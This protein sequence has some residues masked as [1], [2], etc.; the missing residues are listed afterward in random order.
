MNAKTPA[1]RDQTPYGRLTEAGLHG[2]LGYQLAQ[3]AITT[4]RVFSERV[5]QPSELRPVEFTILTLVHE[6]PGVSARQLA[7]AL[8]VTPPN[9]T[10]WIDKLERRGLIERERS[11]TDRRAQHIRTT[12]AGTTLARQSVEQVLEGEQTT[13]AALSPAE[14]AMLIE[15]LHK[16]ARCRRR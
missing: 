4:T 16:V 2:I 3:A 13:L 1:A 14:R 5:G 6:N 8:A 9:I 15:L 11:T 12:P 7:D 10:M